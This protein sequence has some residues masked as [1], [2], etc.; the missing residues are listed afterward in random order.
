MTL[1]SAVIL[2]VDSDNSVCTAIAARLCEL[3]VGRVLMACSSSEAF[4][5]LQ[6][7]PADIVIAEKNIPTVDGS[8]FF[9]CLRRHTYLARLPCILMLG[10]GEFD[11]IHELITCDVTGVLLKPILAADIDLCLDRAAKY[12][13]SPA[14]AWEPSEDS[15]ARTRIERPRRPRLLIVDD[16]PDNLSLTADLFMHDYRVQVTRYGHS[17]LAICTSCAPPDLLLLDVM[18]PGMDG[19]ELASRL[20]K[21]IRTSR[22]PIIFISAIDDPI[23]RCKGL[24]FGAIH[25]ETKP[26]EPEAFKLRVGNLFRHFSLRW[27][28]QV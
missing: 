12:L 22:I 25:F 28:F 27:E 4:K 24:E 13:V 8:T 16:T 9:Q 26:I 17:A 23:V 19:F 20:G 21:D 5:I 10:E 15:A 6:S 18:M 11:Q 2:V 3:G 14:R 1:S 7:W